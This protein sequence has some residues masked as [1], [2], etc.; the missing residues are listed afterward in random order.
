MAVVVASAKP[1]PVKE[2]I[3]N[4]LH[5]PAQFSTM[6]WTA[7]KRTNEKII[8]RMRG[9][10]RMDW[11]AEFLS[12]A[13]ANV[14]EN[15]RQ[16]NIY[17]IRAPRPVGIITFEDVIDTILQK[18]SRDEKDFFG[19]RTRSPLE[20][21]PSIHVPKA[22]KSL[23]TPP[24]HST[25]RF[26]T[27]SKPREA[28]VNNLDGARDRKP[29][30]SYTDDSDGGFHGANDS[31]G[32]RCS[33]YDGRLTALD[34]ADLTAMSVSLGNPYSQAKAASLPSRKIQPKEGISPRHVSASSALPTNSPAAEV[35]SSLSAS[36]EVETSGET[37][38]TLSSWCEDYY[39][40]EHNLDSESLYDALPV[41]MQSMQDRKF[42]YD[43]DCPRELGTITEERSNRSCE[44]LT[45][46]F[47]PY[48]GF[49]PELLDTVNENRVSKYASH[50]LPRMP[51]PENDCNFIPV[52]EKTLVDCRVPLPSQQ[53]TQPN[54]DLAAPRCSS[55]WF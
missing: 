19:R 7:T 49:P 23:K 37:I 52:P 48:E 47:R 45:D 54:M 26:R 14:A 3:P 25:L 39:E 46:N 44:N 16:Q 50:T 41:T 53:M 42:S 6:H 33:R 17:G 12:T 4:V 2:E 27:L 9:G 5:D 38:M 10:Q 32:S 22:R 15:G 34:I 40:R 1:G 28:T 11:T 8:S 51:G 21:L 30:S 31:A 20:S 24:G 18:A 35:H 13:R 43:R 55:L 29:S 36:H